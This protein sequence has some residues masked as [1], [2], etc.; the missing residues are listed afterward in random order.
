MCQVS[1]VQKC[2]EGRLLGSM[3]QHID[4]SL[5]GCYDPNWLKTSPWYDFKMYAAS[6]QPM[7]TTFHIHWPTLTA[8]A[9]SACRYWGTLAPWTWV[10]WAIMWVSF[11]W[12][13]ALLVARAVV[14]ERP[15]KWRLHTFHQISKLQASKQ[16]KQ[17]SN[18]LMQSQSDVCN[19]LIRDSGIRLQS[20][21]ESWI[22]G[23]SWGSAFPN[24]N[25]IEWKRLH[26]CLPLLLLTGFFRNFKEKSEHGTWQTLNQIRSRP[27]VSSFFDCIWAHRILSIVS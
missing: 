12:T 2:V 6:V 17:A 7:T 13:K 27:A 4:V 10:M 20:V 11:H 16:A 22:N 5:R 26:T 25:I 18:N 15:W 24:V 21:L 19:I 23:S 1:I 9:S 14:G 3:A 8:T